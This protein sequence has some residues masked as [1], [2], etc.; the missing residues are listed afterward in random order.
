MG[1]LASGLAHAHDR[2]VIHRDL[3]PANILLTDD[4]QPMLLDFNLSTNYRLAN[5]SRLGGTLPYMAPEQLQ[6]FGGEKTTTDGRS[7]IYSLGLVI[8]QLLTGVSTFPH[9]AGS[10][11]DAI[12]LML[13]D[14]RD[15]PPSLHERNQAVTPAVEAIIH[16]CLAFAPGERYQ[17]AQQLVDDVER[18]LSHRP[19]KFASGSC[20]AQQIAKWRLR[21]PKLSSATSVAIAATVLMT[22]AGG[23]A[24]TYWQRHTTALASERREQARLSAA[25]HLLQTLQTAHIQQ[26]WRGPRIGAHCNG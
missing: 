17:S 3:K 10:I 26:A 22:I 8:Y 19:L 21:H 14:R 15:A 7:D 9:R 4:G 13:E 23:T 16:K 24:I 5:A 6:S 11:R 20:R 12:P 25:E 18:Q 2:G 1:R